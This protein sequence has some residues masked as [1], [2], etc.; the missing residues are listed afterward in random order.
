MK[1]GRGFFSFSPRR[2]SF[3]TLHSFSFRFFLLLL[4]KSSSPVSFPLA[5]LPLPPPPTSAFPPFFQQQK[6]T[7]WRRAMPRRESRSAASARATSEVR[8]KRRR[9]FC[10]RVFNRLRRRRRSELLSSP[11]SGLAEACRHWAN[12]LEMQSASLT[13]R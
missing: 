4:L 3:E 8:E 13:S 1:K 6:Q 2:T 7:P 10:F 5:P 11:F 9:E 12:P